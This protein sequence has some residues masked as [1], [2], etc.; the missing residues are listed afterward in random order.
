MVGG[1]QHEPAAIGGNRFAR[2]VHAVGGANGLGTVF[3][4]SYGGEIIARAVNAGSKIDEVVFLS[5]PVHT[6]HRRMLSAVRRVVDVRLRSTSFSRLL[7][8]RRSSLP[9]GTWSSTS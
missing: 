7:A 4:H 9:L 5:A 2:W 3:G 6:H 1:L 8:H